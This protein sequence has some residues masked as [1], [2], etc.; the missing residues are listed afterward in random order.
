MLPAQP[1]DIPH[2]F[3]GFD[4]RD[5]DTDDEQSVA[6]CDDVGVE[7]PASSKPASSTNY[8]SGAAEE[9]AKSRSSND[10]DDDWDELQSVSIYFAFCT[11]IL[12]VTCL[13]VC[14]LP[15]KSAHHVPRILA[16]TFLL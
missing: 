1:A 3:D 10:D 13:H 5:A 8:Q 12:A 11:Y 7:E 6:S 4:G 9:S 2:D 16:F 14:I 15:S